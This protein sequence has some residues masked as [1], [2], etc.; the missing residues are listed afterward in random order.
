MAVMTDYR[1][2]VR[3]WPESERPSEKLAQYGASALSTAELLAIILRTGTPREDVVALAQRLLVQK[4]G[5][6]G[7]A[8]TSMT[9][10]AAEH[11]LGLAKGAQLKAALELGKRLLQDPRA[12]RA[13]VRSPK[14]VADL[15]MWEMGLLQQEV[16]RTILLNTKNHVIASPVIYQG[17][18]NTSVI[19][20]GELFRE[21]VKHNCAAMVVVH[22]HPSGDPT[23]SPEDVAVTREIVAAGK[24]LDIEVL[25][26]LVIGHQR[27]VSLKERGLGF[28]P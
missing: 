26:H 9:E 14:D 3:E 5:L 24:L 23:P 1:L 8:D 7:L 16:L 22:N 19:R 2:S 11:G 28:G 10:L 6:L 4:G 21:A 13:Q 12:A 20:V 15:V 27:F 17:S 25:D 18:L